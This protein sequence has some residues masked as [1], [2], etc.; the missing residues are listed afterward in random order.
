MS[1]VFISYKREDQGRVAPLVEALRAGGIETWW[2]QDIPAGGS[3]RETIAEKLDAAALCVAIWSEN[4]IGPNGRFVREEAERAARR[5]AYLGVLIDPVPPPFGFSE[6]QAVDLGTWRGRAD[7]PQLNYFLETVRARLTGGP[8]PRAEMPKPGAGKRGIG[9]PLL[10]GLVLVAAL[11][12][13]AFALRPLVSGGGSGPPPSATEFVNRELAGIDCTWAQ[14][15]AVPPAESGLPMQLSGVASAPP[16]VRE[17]LLQRAQAQD[18]PLQ[19]IDVGPLAATPQAVC[20]QLNAL[21]AF[22]VPNSDRFQVVP[23][24]GSLERSGGSLS[25]LVEVEFDLTR[26]PRH[27]AL[28]GLDDQNG[29]EVL[30]PDVRRGPPG[31]S[32]PDRPVLK[33]VFEDEGRNVRNVGLLLLSGEGPIE[34]SALLPEARPDSADTLQRLAQAAQAGG[35]K[36]ELGLVRCGFEAGPGQRC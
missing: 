5:T 15:S 25:G 28:L 18:V 2:D 1:H 3:W 24:R 9:R 8:P 14:I 6:W 34:L 23:E 19:D 11:A 29:L 33:L 35:W 22:R 13:G 7:D 10:V 12:A 32:D 27:A 30:V 16:V 17:L 36:V 20:P 31:G 21:R 4:S 26:I